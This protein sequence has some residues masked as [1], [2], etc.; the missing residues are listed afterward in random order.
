LSYLHITNWEHFQHYKNRRPKWIKFYTDLLEPTNKLNELPVTT[1]FLFDRLLLLAANHD[2]LFL[3]D[4]EWIASVVRMDP[5]DCANGLSTLLKG[6]WLR[7]T[8]TKRRASKPASASAPKALDTELE[9]EKEKE[10][11]VNLGEKV[12]EGEPSQI[13]SHARAILDQLRSRGAA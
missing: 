9:L 5:Q 1:R 3:N 8:K 4:S 6:R 11:A 7:E 10:K 13:G 2:N 12:R